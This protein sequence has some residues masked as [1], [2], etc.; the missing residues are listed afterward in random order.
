[1]KI[2]KLP[3]DLKRDMQLL[4]LQTDQLVITLTEQINALRQKN[5]QVE[6]EYIDARAKNNTYET[7]ELKLKREIQS[8][9]E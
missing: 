3:K 4:N 5:L 9:N 1:L 6:N 8:L 2:L 7:T